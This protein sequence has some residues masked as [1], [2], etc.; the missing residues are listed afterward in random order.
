MS[1][2]LVGTDKFMKLNFAATGSRILS[3]GGS[4]ALTQK[5]E[6]GGYPAESEPGVDVVLVGDGAT[7]FWTNPRSL[8]AGSP[9]VSLVIR[10][11]FLKAL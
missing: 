6:A 3:Y 8:H 4:L 2:Q 5:F 1:C 7:L 9:L 11:S 10:N